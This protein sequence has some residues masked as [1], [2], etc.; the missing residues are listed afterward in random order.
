M[1][2]I[3]PITHHFISL[4]ISVDCRQWLKS[5]LAV[6]L[7]ITNQ[8]SLM[9]D[10]IEERFTDIYEKV[11]SIL[12]ELKANVDSVTT[13]IHSMFDILVRKLTNILQETEQIEIRKEAA[14]TTV[15]ILYHI[16]DFQERFYD[17]P[18]FFQERN[19]V[20]FS[21]K[22]FMK[23]FFENSESIRLFVPFM[24]LT[25]EQSGK[26]FSVPYAA[27][28]T[29]YVLKNYDLAM[30]ILDLMQDNEVQNWDDLFR[31]MGTK[32]MT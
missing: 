22:C 8:N 21:F 14:V 26:I 13:I 29:L 1:V 11:L 25:R 9:I 28:F 31:F 10:L 16:M 2:I 12:R 5:E 30:H 24:N 19:N 27:V 32:R 7:L 23:L 18:C 15:K 17:M 3:Q 6:I 20:I 4:G